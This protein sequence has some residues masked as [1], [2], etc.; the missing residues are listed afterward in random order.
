MRR[1]MSNMEV[2][3]QFLTN[4]SLVSIRRLARL[5]RRTI[6]LLRHATTVGI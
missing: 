3:L 4:P 6:E 1:P 2:I 5:R